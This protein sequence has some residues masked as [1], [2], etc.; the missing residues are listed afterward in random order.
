MKIQP[1][2]NIP[3]PGYPDKSRWLAAPLA[4]GLTAAMALGMGA[5]GG[6]V[7]ADDQTT[8]GSAAVQTAISTAQSTAQATTAQPTTATTIR[9]RTATARA[10]TTTGRTATEYVIMGDF[11]VP[12]PEPT[13]TT[14]TTT[15]V[16]MGT[17]AMIPE[18][19]N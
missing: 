19:E 8:T 5:C 1:V 7:A 14:T 10:T 6:R 17:Y 13:T 9:P 2:E 11:P 12:V 18:Q 4:V 16:I 3:A 15:Y